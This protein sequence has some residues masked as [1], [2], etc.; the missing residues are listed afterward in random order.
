MWELSFSPLL[1]VLVA[2]MLPIG[3]LR[4]GIPLGIIGLNLH[5]FPVFITSLIGNLIPVL[6]ILI[7]LIFSAKDV[8]TS[9]K[10]KILT[11]IIWNSVTC[12]HLRKL[13]FHSKMIAKVKTRLVSQKPVGNFLF[14]FTSW[15]I[16]KLF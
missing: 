1:Q 12:T 6:P 7:M 2:S 9:A 15:L 14:R 13:V 10:M 11:V 5:W 3:E 16:L 8:Y 4:L